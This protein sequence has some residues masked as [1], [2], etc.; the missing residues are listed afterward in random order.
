MLISSVF[1]WIFNDG[2]IHGVSKI[3]DLA[4]SALVLIGYGPFE[5]AV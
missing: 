1:E 5:T 4:I 2:W 3:K